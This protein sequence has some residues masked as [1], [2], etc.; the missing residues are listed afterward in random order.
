MTN[1]FEII[2]YI[3]TTLA[4]PDVSDKAKIMA[5]TFVI[6]RVVNG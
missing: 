1:P 5:A 6:D 4:R 2:S 3:E